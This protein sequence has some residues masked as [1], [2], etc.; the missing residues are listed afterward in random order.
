M[1]KYNVIITTTI[2][3]LE[4]LVS[5]SLKDGWSCQGSIVVVRGGLGNNEYYQAM[6]K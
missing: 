5:S 1:K 3:L 2:K 6:V 4:S